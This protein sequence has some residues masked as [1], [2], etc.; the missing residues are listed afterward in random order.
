MT[1][2]GEDLQIWGCISQGLTFRCSMAVIGVKMV[3][4]VLR[5]ELA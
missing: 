2:F 5:L 3:V 4:R 1:L